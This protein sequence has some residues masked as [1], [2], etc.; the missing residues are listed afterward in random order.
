MG[1]RSSRQRGLPS[2]QHRC[3]QLPGG[4]GHRVLTPMW[5]SPWGP[6]CGAQGVPT[7]PRV[8]I[9]PIS[10]DPPSRSAPPVASPR[11]TAHPAQPPPPVPAHPSAGAALWGCGTGQKRGV[12]LA[13]HPVALC[14]KAFACRRCGGGR[15]GGS[16]GGRSAVSPTPPLTPRSRRAQPS[17][18]VPRAAP[19]GGR[20]GPPCPHPNAQSTPPRWCHPAPPRATC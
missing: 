16:Q 17:P 12:T 1:V 4:K 8:P 15:W 5:G 6:H 20:C 3:W 9:P 14:P 10:C 2:S 13:P 18:H 7:P 19:T 11:P